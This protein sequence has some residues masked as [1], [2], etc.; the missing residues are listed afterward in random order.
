MEENPMQ[1]ELPEESDG[2]DRLVWLNLL[3]ILLD[4]LLNGGRLS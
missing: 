4:W 2:Q 3:L 1:G